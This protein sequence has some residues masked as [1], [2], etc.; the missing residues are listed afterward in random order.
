MQSTLASILVICFTCGMDNYV[1]GVS[2]VDLG[3]HEEGFVRSGALAHLR[4]FLQTTPPF[5][6][7]TTLFT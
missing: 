1:I 6:P 4:N 3:F 5:L 7:K 2:V